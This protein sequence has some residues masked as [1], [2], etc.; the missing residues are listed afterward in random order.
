MMLSI[1]AINPV[2]TWPISSGMTSTAVVRTSFRKPE[3]PG[4]TETCIGQSFLGESERL[5]SVAVYPTRLESAASRTLPEL[6]HACALIG[7]EYSYASEDARYGHF[8][9]SRAWQIGLGHSR[10]LYAIIPPFS[11]FCALRAVHP[12]FRRPPPACIFKRLIQWH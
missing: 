9:S 4:A 1:K 8:A 10:A 11:C 12:F 3:A 5:F 6:R 7:S 2:D